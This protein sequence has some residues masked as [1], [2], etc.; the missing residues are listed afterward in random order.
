MLELISVSLFAAFFIVILSEYLFLGIYKSI[1]SLS[2]TAFAV[3]LYEP[4]PIRHNIVIAVAAAFLSLV[5][6]AYVQKLDDI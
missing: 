6:S 3:E 5:V 1:V 4:F 2:L